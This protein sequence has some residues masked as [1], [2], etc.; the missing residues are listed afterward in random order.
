MRLYELPA[1]FA[2]VEAMLIDGELDEAAM[3]KLAALE[4]TLNEKVQSCLCVSRNFSARADARKAEADRLAALAK[5]DRGNSDRLKNYVQDTLEKLGV[6]KV[7]TELFK[8]RIQDNPPSVVVSEAVD[9]DWLPKEMVRITKE[10]D[11]K[12]VLAAGNMGLPLPE[13]IQIIQTK[14][15]R[16]Q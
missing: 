10:V 9:L 15:L 7:E 1:A 2:E 13:G 12:K 6:A 16:V 14:S 8:V 11:K 3:A 5:S 4:G